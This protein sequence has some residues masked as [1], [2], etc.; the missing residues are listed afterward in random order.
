VPAAADRDRAKKFPMTFSTPDPLALAYGDQ[1]YCQWLI[2]HWQE[3]CIDTVSGWPI[4][5][6]AGLY[7]R[8]ARDLSPFHS[9][10][11]SQI[12]VTCIHE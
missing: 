9:K 3:E 5:R 7:L 6:L 10:I 4:T 8:E 11:L 12:S 1:A 2:E